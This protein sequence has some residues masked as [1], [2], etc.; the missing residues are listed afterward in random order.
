MIKIKIDKKATEIEMRGTMG[1]LVNDALNL[2]GH[3]NGENNKK[4]NTMVSRLLMCGLPILIERKEAQ[5]I[6]DS[7]Y[8]AWDASSDSKE[9]ADFLEEKTGVKVISGNDVTEVLKQLEKEIDKIMS[10]KGGKKND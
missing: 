6:F 4:T 3:I 10:K 7:V 2:A 1:D 8:D 5:E 9:T